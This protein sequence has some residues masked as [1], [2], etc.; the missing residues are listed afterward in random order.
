MSGNFLKWVLDL[1]AHELD[2]MATKERQANNEPN[3]QRKGIKGQLEE[4]DDAAK[5]KTDD[6]GDKTEQGFADCRDGAY[7]SG[8]AIYHLNCSRQAKA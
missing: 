1:T 5:G 3:K 4:K 6:D 8:Q 7:G 2:W